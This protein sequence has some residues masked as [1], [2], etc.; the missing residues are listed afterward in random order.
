MCGCEE[1]LYL[2]GGERFDG[3]SRVSGGERLAFGCLRERGLLRGSSRRKYPMCF[4][5]ISSRKGGKLD[6][7][8]FQRKEYHIHLHVLSLLP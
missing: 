3:L 6:I 1:R 5:M 4:A 7:S 2:L 8:G